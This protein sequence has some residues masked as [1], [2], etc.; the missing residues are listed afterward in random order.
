MIYLAYITLIFFTIRFLVAL[1]NVI[2]SPVLKNRRLHEIPAI[3]V[4]IPARNEEET[5]GSILG[6]LQQIP[7][8]NMEVIVFNDQSTDNTAALVNSLIAK[9]P[10]L[11][12]INSAGLPDGWLGKN[13]ACHQLA[14]NASGEYLLFLDADV[15][16]KPDAIESALAQMQK[17][18]LKL[19]SI[20]PKQIMKTTGEKITVPIMNSILLS[21]LP[22]ILTRTSKR[23]SLAAANGQFMLFEAGMYHQIKPHETMKAQ[24]VE[25]ILIARYFKENGLKM[26]CMTGNNSITCR[27]YSSFQEAAYGFS[28]NVAEFFGGSHLAAFVYWFIGTFGIFSVIFSLNL[29]WMVLT[30][31]LIAAVKILV[32]VSG[33]QNLWESLIFALPQQIVL[34]N[35]IS[36]SF[37]NKKRKEYKWKGRTIG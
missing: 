27:M 8:K 9:D 16:V 33:K 29:F 28:K 5:I 10:R 32:S 31:V 12:L 14:K 7:H 19:L 21:M 6:D 18:N 34:G 13:Y 11:K 20:F 23:A 3:S 4:L 15:R 37:Q 36:L 26:Q 22:L 24:K 1:T 30:F 25:D 2:F 17:H 35:I